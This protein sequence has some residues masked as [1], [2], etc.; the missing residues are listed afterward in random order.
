VF[1]KKA[2]KNKNTRFYPGSP[3]LKGYIQSFANQQ[4]FPLTKITKISLTKQTL[5]ISKNTQL[6][7]VINLLNPSASYKYIPDIT[8]SVINQP[9][10]P[11]S[12]LNTGQNP[13]HSQNYNT[14]FNSQQLRFQYTEMSSSI[15]HISTSLLNR[16][17]NY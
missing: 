12:K 17:Q 13:L 11:F 6:P 9:T 4:R 3:F 16:L 1:K 7:A 5:A 14:L 15:Q 10:E 8:V 2:R